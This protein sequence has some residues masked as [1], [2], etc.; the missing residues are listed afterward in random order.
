VQ[1]SA[2]EA[3]AGMSKRAIR[4]A[5][6]VGVVLLAS[7]VVVSLAAAYKTGRYEG[8]TSQDESISFRAKKQ[9][10]KDFLYR[11]IVDCEDGSQE[12][13]DAKEGAA[14]T[15]DRGKFKVTFLG[16]GIT[17]VVKGKLKRK[18]GEGTIETEGIGQ[19]GVACSSTVDWSARKQ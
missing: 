16:E 6:I 10:V 14:P 12:A 17:S 9:G 1:E 7:A 4:T 13:I 15:N 8:P 2:I 19:A 3:E 5:T 11:V 18:R